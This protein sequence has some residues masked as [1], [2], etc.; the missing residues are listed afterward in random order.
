MSSTTPANMTRNV[1]PTWATTCAGSNDSS[2]SIFNFMSLY[3]ICVTTGHAARVSVSHITGF[4]DVTLFCRFPT[5]T[6]TATPRTC[7]CPCKQCASVIVAACPPP[8]VIA[9]TASEQNSDETPL[10]VSP[11]AKQTR[12]RRCEVE[13]LRD[14]E[15]DINLLLTLPSYNI[16]TIIAAAIHITAIHFP[17][18]HIATI[19]PV[20]AI[21]I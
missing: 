6:T 17:A 8:S 14:G 20:A 7:R 5:P 9:L 19:H 4:Q 15:E 1:A 3:D 10:P 11:P 2:P 21:S 13:L 18:I 16:I 12:K